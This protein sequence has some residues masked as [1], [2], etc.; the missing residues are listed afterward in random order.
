[1]LRRFSSFK[2]P[3]LPFGMNSLE[4]EYDARTLEFHH[5]KHH[6]SYVSQLNS[7]LKEDKITLLEVIQEKSRDL[8]AARNFG[9]GHY[10]HSLF[11]LNIGKTG[12][13]KP[14]WKLIKDIERDFGSFDKFKEVF[15]Q[16]SASQFGSGW[17]WLSLSP[18]GKLIV[19]STQNQD[20]PLMKGVVSDLAL[21]FLTCDVWEHAYYLQYQHQRP[22]YISKFWNI[23]NWPKIESIYEEFILKGKPVPA[24]ELLDY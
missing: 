23:I 11:W 6:S 2:L 9:G 1:M 19:T 8:K 5:G 10:N 21:P 4:P 22:L 24:D 18:Q 16:A 17:G 13:D 12:A 15:S 20:N 3:K 7:S 14:K